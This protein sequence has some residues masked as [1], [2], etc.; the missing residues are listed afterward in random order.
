MIMQI[1]ETLRTASI[2]IRT[3]LIHYFEIFSLIAYLLQL[4]ANQ[5][6]SAM[7]CYQR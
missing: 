7:N 4:M 6:R 2:L 3:S 1:N 5:T